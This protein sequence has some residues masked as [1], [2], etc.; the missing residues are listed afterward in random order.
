MK[1]KNPEFRAF[2]LF[3]YALY[4]PLTGLA[5]QHFYQVMPLIKTILLV[6]LIYNE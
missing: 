6:N 5:G 1:K 3:I 4:T 2:L